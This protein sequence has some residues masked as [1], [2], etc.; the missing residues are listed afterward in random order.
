MLFRLVLFLLLPWS[1]FAQVRLCA[2][3]IQNF[4]KSKSDSE[5]V[6]MAGLLRGFDVVA[7]VEV[8]AGNGGAQAVARLADELNRRGEKWD[9]TVSNPTTGTPGSSERYAFLWKTAK[10]RK[11]AGET[12]DT[13]F[14][15]SI[16]REP[17]VASFSE[18]GHEFSVAVFHAVP[19]SKQP[20]REIKFLKHFPSAYRQ[21]PLIICGDFNCAQSHSVFN[22]LK[23]VGY[24]PAL[25]GCKTSL[26][27][28][29]KNGECLASEY[30]NLF[31]PSASITV[32]RAGVVAFYSDFVSL[33][34]ARKIS[35]HLPVYI[36]FSAR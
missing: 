30:D 6:Y 34:S 20:E 28:E 19:K 32:S 2:W 9:Y 8:V 14:E 18:K 22:P 4:G 11:L 15:A 31:Y 27:N 33:R 36:E 16:E 35:D 7:L 3:N 1:A 25:E 24:V 10:L 12:L 23:S 17:Y 5:I 29:P 26:K 13:V 21:R